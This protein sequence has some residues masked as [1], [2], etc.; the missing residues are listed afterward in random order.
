M[1][2]PILFLY[3]AS[4]TSFISSVDNQKSETLSTT[5]VLSFIYKCMPCYMF[6]QDLQVLPLL[7]Y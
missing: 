3:G 4:S 5:V 6:A 2:E 7:R 1:H